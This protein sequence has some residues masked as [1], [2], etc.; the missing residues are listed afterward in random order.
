M[1][2]QIL[3]P[4]FGSLALSA[5]VAV[6]PL[7]TLFVLLGVFRVKAWKAALVGLV[8][9]LVLAVLVWQMPPL[10]ALSATAEGAL[11]GIVPI[12]WILVNALWVYRL[13]VV[14]GW[15][16]VLGDRIRAISDDQRILAILIAFCFGALLESLAG[17]GAPVAISIAMLIAAGMKPLKAAIVSLLANTAPVAFGAM[18]APIIALSGVTGIDIHLLSQMAGRQTPF[19]AMIVPLILV[20]IVD[21]M[22]GVRQTWPVAVVAGIAFAVAQF[23]TANFIAVEITDVVASVVTVAAVLIML[24]FWKPSETLV[25]DAADREAGIA[26]ASAA[27][28]AGTSQSRT[29]SDTGSGTRSD[30]RVRVAEAVRVD[31]AS[32]SRGNLTWNAVMPY[33]VIIAVFSV[34]QIPVIKQFLAQSVTL[35]FPWPGLEIANAAGD[36]VGTTFSLNV[37]GTGGTL[38]LLSGIIVALIYR[39]RPKDAVAA[40]GHTLN[41]LR[42]TIVTVV[43]VLA[44]AYVMN[45]SGQT[46]SLGAALAAT[47]GLFALL[48]PVIGWLGVAITGS[49]TSSNALFGLL[50]VTAAEKAG[51]N[52]ILMAATNSSAGVLGKMLSPQNLAV[53]AAAAGMAGKEGDLFRKLI[54]WSLGLLVV[55]TG[56]I[57]LQSTVLAWM[58]PTP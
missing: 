30:S 10:Q 13:T 43:A 49:D 40:Y 48:S 7:A 14:T 23:V 57:Y 39:I 3:D 4:V 58:V 33:V 19:L 5:L 52:P 29:G 15:F 16:E 54:W 44:L 32:R 11:Y 6:I 53:A 18:A 26:S 12:L 50:Q 1:F 36:P 8:L 41:Q 37:F 56:L 51:L 34:A 47:G 42:F 27:A 35:M 28:A 9:S 38:L 55:F 17:F 24:R 2:Q 21:G 31:T 25:F 45:L 22:R 20:F 46:Q